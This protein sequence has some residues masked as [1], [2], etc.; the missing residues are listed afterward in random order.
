MALV[1]I[2][3]A[4]VSVFLRWRRASAARREALALLESLRSKHRDGLDDAKLAKELSCLLRR[5]AVHHHPTAEAA[6]LVG[7]GW[8][9]F[10]DRGVVGQPF[11]KGVGRWLVSAPYCSETEAIDVDQLFDV[12]RSWLKGLKV[13]NRN[14]RGGG[15]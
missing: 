3:V 10:L 4:G 1:V 9:E 15:L 2:L 11:S 8:L 5:A 14:P 6:G 12:C 13:Q 7:E